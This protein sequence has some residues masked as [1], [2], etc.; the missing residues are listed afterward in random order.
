M[1]KFTISPRTQE[2]FFNFRYDGYLYITT[3]GSYQFQTT[4]SDGTRVEIDGAVVVNNDGVHEAQTVTGSSRTLSSGPRRIK[5]K[6]FEYTGS[7]VITVKYK[8]PDTGGS[9]LTIPESV[10]RSTSPG[11]SSSGRIGEPEKE[12]TTMSDEHLVSVY[13]N[14]A[15][16]DN[17]NLQLERTLDAAVDDE[18]VHVSIIDMNGRAYLQQETTSGEAARGV[19]LIAGQ[20]LNNGMYLMVIRRNGKT[21]K[22]LIAIRN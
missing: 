7:A 9:W 16:S 6:Y 13:P 8:G 5:V 10:L 2:D 11:S 12:E 17:L 21:T 14:P 4:S 15:P 18:P 3:G 19:Q 22:K 1:T 20:R